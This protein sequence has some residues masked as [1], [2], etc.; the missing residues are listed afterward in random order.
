MN[1]VVLIGRLTKDPELKFTPGTG[2][3]VASFTL[4][5]DRRFK[6]EGQQEADFIPIVVW[7]K[8]AEST[9]NYMSKGKLMGVSGRIQTR[10]Y[11]AKDGTRR[12]VTE[13]VAEEVQFLEWGSSNNNS[14]ANDQFN[15]GNENGSMQL[16]DNNDITPIDDGDIPF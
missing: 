6:K 9:A 13:I 8:Q 7:G 12:Y 10:S 2:T 15:N 4:A 14:M 5:V 16:P 1:K 3:A 11:D